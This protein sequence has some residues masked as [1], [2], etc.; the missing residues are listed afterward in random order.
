MSTLHWSRIISPGAKNTIYRVNL[1]PFLKFARKRNN[2][3]NESVCPQTFITDGLLPNETK[4]TVHVTSAM[5]PSIRERIEPV[6][7]QLHHSNH[8]FHLPI[9][10][11]VENLIR[12]LSWRPIPSSRPVIDSSNQALELHEGMRCKLL[13]SAQM[14][15]C[16]LFL[17]L[18]V[19][20]HNQTTVMIRPSEISRRSGRSR[21]SERSR[22]T[23]VRHLFQVAFSWTMLGTK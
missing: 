22:R 4:Q 11:S 5:E 20:K 15:L 16:V 2:A 13:F 3:P 18:T 23:I 9:N 1:A 8:V 6:F 12:S 10:S 21:R 17:N 14:P 7:D 19:T